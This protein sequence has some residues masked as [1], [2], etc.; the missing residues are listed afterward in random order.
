MKTKK[1]NTVQISLF[2][3]QKTKDYVLRELAAQ[4]KAGWEIK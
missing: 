4:I 1:K 3:K 2:T